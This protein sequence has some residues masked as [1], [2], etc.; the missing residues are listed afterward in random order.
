M[1][2]RVCLGLLALLFGF[3][4][5][6]GPPPAGKE[7]PYL[8]TFT[9]KPK[10]LASTGRNAYFILEPGYVLHF[11]GKEAGKKT[12]LRIAV[13]DETR[14]IA[15]VE[16]RV[17]E[18]RETAGGELK[19]VSR[20]F[21]AIAPATG[22]LYYFGEEVDGYEGGKVANHEGSWLAGQGENRFGLALPGAPQ[23]GQRYYQEIAPRTAMDRAEIVSRSGTMVTPAGAF[24][25]VLKIME[26]TPLEPGVR[27][28]KH[29][30]PGI[31]LIKDGSLKLTKYGKETPP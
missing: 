11:E 14:V 24:K 15:G 16:T 20:N 6:A 30:A 7:L 9:V 5:W 1:R 3:A 28:F 10:D 23:V 29:Y 25:D 26:T 13:L 2:T 21:Y 17:V 18:E 12:E 19:E 4:A 8:E 22:D 31:G 27:E